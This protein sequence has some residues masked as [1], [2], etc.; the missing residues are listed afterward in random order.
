MR[1]EANPPLSLSPA[2]RVARGGP[3]E[4]GPGNR[5][6]K[7]QGWTSEGHWHRDG[8]SSHVIMEN[9]FEHLCGGV[10]GW[11]CPYVGRRASLKLSSVKIWRMTMSPAVGGPLRGG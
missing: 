6:G 9:L 10:L 3:E 2:P 1:R 7:G 4:R 8:L 5:S 11:S